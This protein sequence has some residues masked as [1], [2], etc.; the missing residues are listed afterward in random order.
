M[1]PIRL[2][3]IGLAALTI[4]TAVSGTI[5][6]AKS[7]VDGL[8]ST[9]VIQQKQI[10]VLTTD[11]SSAK[12]SNQSLLRENNRKAEESKGVREELDRLRRS[13]AD[14]QERLTKIQKKLRDA[15]EIRRHEAIRN[16]RKAGFLL[17]LVNKDIKCQIENF[18]RV[19]GKCVRGRWVKTG[20]RLV[21]EETKGNTDEN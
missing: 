9:I 6:A 15:E 12:A 4:V 16:S 14:S 7:Y 13:D 1:I 3:L 2:I 11:L 17:R 5:Y 10:T 8:N 21:P 19:D 20:K 18:D